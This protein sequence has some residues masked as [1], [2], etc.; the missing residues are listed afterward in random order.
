MMIKEAVEAI[1]SYLDNE[2][3]IVLD[4]RRLNNHTRTMR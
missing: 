2:V 3:V 4:V 1:V